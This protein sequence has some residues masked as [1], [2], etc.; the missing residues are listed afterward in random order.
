MTCAR[1]GEAIRDTALFRRQ[2][3]DEACALETGDGPIERARAQAATAH[4]GDVLDNRVAMLRAAREA[5]ED[6]QRLLGQLAR[7]EVA[8]RHGPSYVSRYIG[9][10]SST[11]SA[12]RQGCATRTCGPRTAPSRSLRP[13]NGRR[14]GGRPSTA[15]SRR[16]CPY[17]R[18][19][20]G[21]ACRR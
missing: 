2:R 7:S 3:L 16:R 19:C 1:L 11:A 20:T 10:R 6:E 9:S 8:Y 5:D 12:G 13:S 4:V 14:G 21:P 18:T 15:P 17:R